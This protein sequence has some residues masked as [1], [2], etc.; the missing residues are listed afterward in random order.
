VIGSNCGIDHKGTPITGITTDIDA[1][2]RDVSFPDIGADEF[3]NPSP[4]LSSSLAPAA[5]CSGGVFTYTATS[6]TSGA[7]FAWARATVPG[8]AQPGTIGTGNVND[9]LNNTTSSPINV[10][11]VYTTSATGCSNIQNVLVAVNPGPRLSS[12]LT[13]TGICS[14]STFAYTATSTSS[15]AVFSWTRATVTGISQAGTAGSGNVSETLTNTTTG[16]INVT[17]VYNITANGCNNAPGESVVVAISPVPGLSSSLSPVACSGTTFS[18]TPTSTASG[19][20]FTWT[21]ATVSGITE[22]GTSGA[23]NVGEILTNTTSSPI[24]VTYVYAT[25][26]NGCSGGTQNVVVTVNPLPTV[27]LGAFSNPVCIQVPAFNLTG[28]SPAG[29]TYAGPG[30]SGGMFHPSTAGVGAQTITYT[31]T[32]S[33]CSNAASQVLTVQSCTGIEENSISQ[34]IA[35]YPNPTSGLFNIYVKEA[36]FRELIISIVDIQGK[37]VYKVI[38]NAIPSGATYNKAI[39]INNLA[40]GIYYIKFNTDTDATIQKLIVQ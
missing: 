32:V 35:V 27:S 23:G 39:N 29:G 28:G 40:K 16:T 12:T 8:I 19:A 31:A 38:D 33:G 26:T 2:V 4:I 37:E 5:I 15:G 13:P 17:Y 6:A 25:H 20:T 11:Y 34:N 14:G 1:D 3:F 7:T 30:V 18:Y 24:N 10:T 9:T 36:N 22:T 21:R